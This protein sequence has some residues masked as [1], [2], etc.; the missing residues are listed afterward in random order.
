MPVDNAPGGGEGSENNLTWIP[1]DV[2][3]ALK[4]AGYE[5]N[6]RFVASEVL[7]SLMEQYGIDS[8]DDL[9]GDTTIV[10]NGGGGSYSTGPSAAD[11][12]NLAASYRELLH[13]WGIDVTKNLENL[14]SQGKNNEWSTTN[15]IQHLRQTKEYKAVYSG[16]QKGQTEESY[17]S[18]Y[19]AYKDRYKDL[20]RNLT[21][22]AFGFLNKKGVD[23]TEWDRRVAV[24]GQVE[25]NRKLLQNFGEVLRTRGIIGKKEKWGLKQMSDFVSGSGSPAWEKVWEEAA[26]TTGLEQAGFQIG[27]KGDL[28]RKEL[29]QTIKRFEGGDPTKEIENMGADYYSQLAEQVRTTIPASKLAGF[30]L[31]NS[32]ILELSLGGPRAGK[33]AETVQQIFANLDRESEG[34]GAKVQAQ[35]TLEGVQVLGVENRRS[36]TQ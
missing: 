29:L 3:A 4:Q 18:A 33:I 1:D 24:M 17:I 9:P 6:S 32:D 14:I 35:T 28:S 11:L 16:I 27:K 26:F 36:Q 23:Y 21:L 22:E 12:A 13:A 30:K 2:W 19:N 10:V 34:F 20:G 15:F 31:T 25:N 5:G 8:G 7:T